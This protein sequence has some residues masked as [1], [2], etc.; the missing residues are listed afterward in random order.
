MIMSA[1]GGGNLAGILLAGTLPRFKPQAMTILLVGLITAFGA[2]MIMFAFFTIT[3][4]FVVVMV[5]LGV[6]NG[7]LSILL[8]TFLQ[9]NTPK[10]MIGRVMSLVLFANIGLVPVSQA[11]SGALL[12]LS[13]NGMFIVAGFLMML[14][15]AG[16]LLTPDLKIIGVRMAGVEVK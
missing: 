14:I 1:Y 5:L 7:Y 2:A 12:K 9:T 11:L 10:E 13:I 6:G 4:A 15:A 3:L 16:M 8:Y